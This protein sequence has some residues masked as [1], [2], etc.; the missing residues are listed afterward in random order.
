MGGGTTGLSSGSK[1]LRA[2]SH[3]KTL[4]RPVPGGCG[5][6]IRTRHKRVRDRGG[7][8]QAAHFEQHPHQHRECTCQ[9]TK[10]HFEPAVGTFPKIPVGISAEVREIAQGH[11]TALGLFRIQSGNQQAVITDVAQAFLTASAAGDPAFE[12]LD[13]HDA[14]AEVLHPFYAA[15]A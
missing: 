12:P 10:Q 11:A 5:L 1:A 3:P 7:I 8:G 9:L 6:A 4:R 2:R 13:V 14:A 15:S